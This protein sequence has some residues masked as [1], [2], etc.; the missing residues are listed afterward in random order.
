[1][2]MTGI[3]PNAAASCAAEPFVRPVILFDP[4]AMAPDM[5]P[6][7]SSRYRPSS[8]DSARSS[9]TTYQMPAPYSSSTPWFSSVSVSD[10]PPPLLLNASPATALIVTVFVLPCVTIL[11][12]RR[13]PAGVPV[14]RVIVMLPLVVSTGTSWLGA[15]V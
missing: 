9:D 12:P 7:D 1:M 11:T 3:C 15:A 13:L 5:V 4:M 6:P 14:G 10:V 8:P 2:T